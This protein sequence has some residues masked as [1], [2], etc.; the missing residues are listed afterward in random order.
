[1]IFE[2]VLSE[3]LEDHLFDSKFEKHINAYNGHITYI[4]VVKTPGNPFKKRHLP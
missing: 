4:T 1:M 2:S 3:Q